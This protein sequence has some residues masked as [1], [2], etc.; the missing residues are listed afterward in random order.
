MNS[1][2]CCICERH[3]GIYDDDGLVRAKPHNRKVIFFYEDCRG[4]TYETIEKCPGSHR[5]V[6]DNDTY[7]PC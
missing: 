4:G 7:Q 1:Y 2:I 5:L 3:V 6:K